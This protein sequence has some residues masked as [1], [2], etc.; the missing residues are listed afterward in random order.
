MHEA[1]VQQKGRDLRGMWTQVSEAKLSDSGLGPRD[2][3]RRVC[4][5]KRNKREEE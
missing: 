5:K 3:E 4:P 1:K 2:V